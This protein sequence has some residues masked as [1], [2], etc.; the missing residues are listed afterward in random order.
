LKNPTI[1]ISS[2][3]GSCETGMWKHEMWKQGR[4][5]EVMMKAVI[6]P[7]IICID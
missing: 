7:D 6:K 2:A 1:N 4:P 5:S 3:L